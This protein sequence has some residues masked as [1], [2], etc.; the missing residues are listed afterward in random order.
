M[1]DLNKKNISGYKKKQRIFAVKLY[2][3]L[4]DEV[5]LR[6]ICLSNYGGEQGIV[7]FD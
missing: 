2:F 7:I 4:K 6:P 1:Y 5:M 3:H